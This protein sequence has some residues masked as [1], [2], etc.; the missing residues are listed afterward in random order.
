MLS[1]FCTALRHEISSESPWTTALCWSFIDLRDRSCP[2]LQRLIYAKMMI[3]HT[4]C[5]SD[6]LS[7]TMD[8]Q[9]RSADGPECGVP[10]YSLLASAPQHPLALC[11]PLRWVLRSFRA[12]TLR[13]TQRFSCTFHTARASLITPI[14]KWLAV[15]HL[16]SSLWSLWTAPTLPP[17]IHSLNQLRLAAINACYYPNLNS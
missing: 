5:A 13:Q 3:T 12:V 10:C 11:T 7:L 16:C 1:A 17:P 15:V 6:S 2:N 9:M 14:C 4:H 8:P